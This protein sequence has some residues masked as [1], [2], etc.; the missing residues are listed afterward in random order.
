MPITSSY[1][2]S[3]YLNEPNDLLFFAKPGVIDL[4]IEV[5]RDIKNEFIEEHLINIVSVYTAK[6]ILHNIQPI[7]ISY[8]MGY[9]WSF[10]RA[11]IKSK[12][13]F[14]LK[15]LIAKLAV[16]ASRPVFYYYQK[17]EWLNY[18]N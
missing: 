7:P 5:N 12:R 8:S 6:E 3:L 17:H 16:Y 13:K 2:A 4:Y 18:Y 11:R 14:S 10:S 9:D 1:G 15:N